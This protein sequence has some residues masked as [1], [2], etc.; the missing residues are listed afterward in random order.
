MAFEKNEVEGMGFYTLPAFTKTGLVQHV[1]TGR[2]GGFSQGAYGTLNLSLFTKDEPSVVARNRAKLIRALGLAQ[3]DLVGAMQ[4]HG[5]RVFEVTAAEKGRGAFLPET[6]LRGVD[7]LF[8]ATKGVALL[9]Y[10]ADCVP[11]F[12]LDPVKEVVALA[13]AGWRGTLA[14]IVIETVRALSAKG[15][16]PEHLLVGIGP[17]IGPC[18]YQVDQV[19]I[20]QVV[21]AFPTKHDLLLTKR[22]KG[23]AY[24]DLKEA[25]R[26]QLLEVGVREEKIMVSGLCTSCAESEFFSHRRGLLGRQAGLIML[27]K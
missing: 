14:G 26:Q 8:T 19:V 4:V 22:A 24:F 2:S 6:A 3:T 20:E 9:A 13:H 17:S 25:N 15:T 5:T 7:A 1:F 21:A 23:V 11:V 27:K 18:H 12:F 16:R 10:F